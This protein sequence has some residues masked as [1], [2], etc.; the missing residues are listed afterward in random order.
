MESC[1]GPG[2]AE[3]PHLIL[4]QVKLDYISN[5]LP[6]AGCLAKFAFRLQRGS[7]WAKSATRLNYLVLRL[8]GATRCN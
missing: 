1:V 4:L 3:Q 7:K 2:S 8:T 6:Q 5:I